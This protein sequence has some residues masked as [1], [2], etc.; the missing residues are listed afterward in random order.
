M[1]LLVS[2]QL[3]YGGQGS[4]EESPSVPPKFFGSRRSSKQKIFVRRHAREI[5]RSEPKRQPPVGA[6]EKIAPEPER[7]PRLPER[8]QTKQYHSSQV[9]QEMK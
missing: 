3:H 1:F 2:L 7:A 9:M 6:P 8:K 5:E 4:T